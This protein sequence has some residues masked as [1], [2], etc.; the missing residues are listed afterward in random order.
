[1]FPGGGMSQGG[2]R[3]SQNSIPPP[4]RILP[5]ADPSEGVATLATVPPTSSTA[6]GSSQKELLT[7]KLG[8]ATQNM[9]TDKES[10]KSEMMPADLSEASG[11]PRFLTCFRYSCQLSSLHRMHK[12]GN[13]KRIAYDDTSDT[14]EDV[15]TEPDV[16]SVKLQRRSSRIKYRKYLEDYLTESDLESDV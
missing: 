5:L 9:M 13:D 12:H 15:N 1:M 2:G 6:E 16:S 10:R 3:T 4:L 7:G 14:S 8:T 11:T